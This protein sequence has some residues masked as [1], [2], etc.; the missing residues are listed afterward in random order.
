M[1][2]QVPKSGRN[3]LALLGEGLLDAGEF[4]GDGA[5]FVLGLSQLLPVR[6][7]RRLQVPHLLL[8]AAELQQLLLLAGNLNSSFVDAS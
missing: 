5:E 4:A 2:W 6:G 7:H 1:S 8:D 3:L